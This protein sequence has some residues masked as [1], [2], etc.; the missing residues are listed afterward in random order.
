MPDPSVFPPELFV[1]PV[2]AALQ[3][4]RV[5]QF[6]E[7]HREAFIRMRRDAEGQ[8]FTSDGPSQL[9][10]TTLNAAFDDCIGNPSGHFLIEDLASA[11]Y[12]GECGMLESYAD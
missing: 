12:V 5:V 11:R 4:V 10:D 8:R 6:S 7:R 1:V 9:S 2:C 3:Q